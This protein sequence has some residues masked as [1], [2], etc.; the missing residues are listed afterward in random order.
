MSHRNNQYSVRKADRSR[1]DSRSNARKP[2]CKVCHDAGKTE[3]EY[4]SHYVRE[5]PEPNSRVVCP[6]LLCAECKYCYEIGHTPS[7]CPALKEKLR[8]EEKSAKDSARLAKFCENFEKKKQTQPQQQPSS[9]KSAR[10]GGFSALADSSSDDDEELLKAK[11]SKAKK[12]T[13]KEE[14][15]SLVQSKLVKELAS[16][17]AEQPA[18]SW[19]ARVV[20][21]PAPKPQP[22]AMPG[23]VILG[24]FFTGEPLQVRESGFTKA[25][26]LNMGANIYKSSAVQVTQLPRVSRRSWADWSD[27]ED[28]EEDQQQEVA[29]GW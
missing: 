17:A 20:L 18:Q 15:P 4:T 26:G 12:A 21:E 23:M 9:S 2:Y 10:F 28:E 8:L 25:L 16:K 29:D 19:A 24:D 22:R 14:F 6:T 27:D 1:Q 7:C 3:A 5:T 13:P 11:S